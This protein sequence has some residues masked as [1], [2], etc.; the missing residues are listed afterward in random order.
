M[1]PSCRG[2]PVAHYPEESW[3]KFNAL[4]ILDYVGYCLFE[5]PNFT[6][7]LPTDLSLRQVTS[8][9]LRITQS[10]TLSRQISE[11]LTLSSTLPNVT[12]KAA[13]LEAKL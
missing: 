2:Q 11:L 13:T 1:A 5:P 10:W 7:T 9:D 6:L 8:P 12:L 4:D 3:L